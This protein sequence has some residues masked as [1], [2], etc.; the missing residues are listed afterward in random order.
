MKFSGL[1]LKRTFAIVGLLFTTVALITCAVGFANYKLSRVS[2]QL[3]DQLTHR[4]L[5][6]LQELARLQEATLR[7]NAAHTEFVLAKDENAMTAKAKAAN[8][9]AGKIA[10]HLDRLA[11]LLHTPEAARIAGTFKDSLKTC[12]AAATRLQTTL[13]AGEFEKAMATLDND[14]TKAKQALD[15][16]LVALSRHCFAISTEASDSVSHAVARNLR[17]TLTC[18]AIAAAVILFAIVFVQ[19]IAR[20]I[21][22][23]IEGNLDAL[24]AGSDQVQQGAKTLAAGSQSLADG[25]SQQAASLE[26]TSSSLVEIGSM[27]QRN[28]ESAQKAKE[29]AA[30]ARSTA[31]RGATQMAAMQSAMAAINSA[32][33]DITK[34]L[35]TIDEIAFQTNLLALNAAVEAARAGEAGMGFAVVADEVRALAQRSAHAARETAAKIDDSVTKSQQ[36]VRISGEAKESFDAIQQQVHELDGLVSEIAASCAEQSDGIRQLNTA[37]SHM[38]KVTQATA[39]N[40]EET[41][42]AAEELNGQAFTLH[43]AVNSLNALAGAAAVKTRMRL[44]SV[45]SDGGLV[46]AEP[47]R[48]A[49]D[50][51]IRSTRKAAERSEPE[52]ADRV[53]ARFF[54]R[55]RRSGATL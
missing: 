19:A 35:K 2:S 3:T 41:A 26:E 36:G 53:N 11:D 22:R 40:A 45:M 28:A 18:T 42:S 17:I 33:A 54:N 25:A 5:P 7:Y 46:K 52:L 38:D 44:S 34:I 21:S 15:A 55:G 8:D 27:T 31:D 4:D 48:L 39:A 13:K 14:V 12:E 51:P 50:Y 29:T 6:A 32:S 10:A 43:E 24:A 30:L 49:S 1:N 20:R 47:A 16:N 23:K 37:V 9:W